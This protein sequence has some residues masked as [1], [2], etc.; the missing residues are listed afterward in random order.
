MFRPLYGLHRD[1]GDKVISAG[2]FAHS[3]QLSDWLKGLDLRDGD[4]V[5]FHETKTR[6]EFEEV[7]EA[8]SPVPPIPLRVEPDDVD[9]FAPKF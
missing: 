9:D 1:G 8:P 4:F 6:P 5:E 3:F 7:P 2:S